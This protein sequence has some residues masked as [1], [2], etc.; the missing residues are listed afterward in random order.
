MNKSDWQCAFFNGGLCVLCVCVEGGSLVIKL[1]N[2]PGAL[3]YLG[4]QVLNHTSGSLFILTHN[5]VR[6]HRLMAYST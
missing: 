5:C 1:L 4:I 3:G 6:I 2:V